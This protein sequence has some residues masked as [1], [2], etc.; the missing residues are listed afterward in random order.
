MGWRYV[1][2]RVFYALR[3]RLGILKKQFP[4]NPPR[5]EFISLENW[6]ALPQKFFFE[7]KESIQFAKNKN[8]GL[9]NR[10]IDFQSGKLWF[11]NATQYQ[12]GKNYDWLTNPSNGYK[13]DI[14]KHW[15]E[16]SDLSA[17]AGDIK[18]V[19]EKSRFS[20]LYDLI[21]YDDHFEEDL[22]EMV[23]AEIDSWIDA[24]PINQGPNYKCSQEISLRLINWIFALNYY[25]NTAALSEERFLK[26]QHF[27]YWQ[28]RHVYSNINFSRYTV[29]NNHALT[30]CL[31]L[32][33][34]GLL[35][36][37]FPESANWKEEGKTWFEEE[38]MYQ[39][40]EDGTFLQF[41][42]NYHR[43][44]IQLLTIGFR[45]ADVND[46]KFSPEIYERAKKSLNYL[47]QCQAGKGGELPNYGANDGALFF[48][49][50]DAAYRDFRPQLNALNYF[51]SGKY[52]F[53]GL[54]QG[55]SE[56]IYWL[57]L[58][59]S[60]PVDTDFSLTKNSISIFPQGGIYTI[61]DGDTF[62]FIKCA[63]YRDRPS[64]ADN[65]HVDIWVN[66]E[67]IFR[68]AG[69]YQYNTEPGL[70]RYFAGTKGHNTVMLGGYDQ[71]H[72]GPRFIWLNWSKV[73]DSGL[74]EN[75]TFIEFEGKIAV[76]DHVDKG[77]THQR[78]IKKQKGKAVWIVED[79]V[80]H[81]T[82]Y[83]IS[84][85]WH[86]D[87]L[88]MEKIDIQSSTDKKI[89]GA[90]LYSSEYGKKIESACMVCSTNKNRI[91]TSI[92]IFNTMQHLQ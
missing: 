86:F 28:L 63:E 60:R 87:P 41:S 78:T 9:L 45:I 88:N 59:K 43:V 55:I 19:W 69:T 29:R 33:M 62:T 90:A 58:D 38:I 10:F 65:L 26:Y 64:Q 56:D 77:I 74:T 34:G 70:V 25:K 76:F 5:K 61:N 14:S 81:N 6:K 67:N 39:V 85:R 11:F 89:I 30:E 44:L 32:Y 50:N 79:I 84:Q 35:F 23:F 16:I 47:Y 83:P 18:Y 27:I 46:E 66:G 42:H 53:S 36:P 3:A 31:M 1:Q 80:N 82:K 75:D 48:K 92:E 22:S 21:R 51:F 71:M 2:F 72:K 49:W 91:K 8:Q 4:V 13:Y 7:S 73:I 17:D 68:D 24:N 20:Y 40:Y 12:I 52:L 54:D 15:S 57:G 37:F